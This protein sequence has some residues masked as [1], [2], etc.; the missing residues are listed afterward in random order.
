MEMMYRTVGQALEKAG[1]SNE[2]HPQDYLNFYCL[3]KR[4]LGL[5][6]GS[7]QTNQ[8]SESSALVRVIF[9]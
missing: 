5:P 2:N 7:L 9:P 1:L 8:P 4:E 6:K 3:G